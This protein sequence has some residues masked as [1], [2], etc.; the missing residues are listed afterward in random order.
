MDFFPQSPHLSF[1]FA[2][3]FDCSASFISSS[4][5]AVTLFFSLFQESD[6]ASVIAL[7]FRVILPL[8]LVACLICF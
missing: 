5:F 7:T 3:T 1:L 4:D 2:S 8:A 6:A